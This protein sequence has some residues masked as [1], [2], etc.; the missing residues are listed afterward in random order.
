M[1]VGRMG[2]F[3]ISARAVA[4]GTRFAGVFRITRPQQD[5]TVTLPFQEQDELEETFDTREEAIEPPTRTPRRWSKVAIN[6]R[7]AEG[8][9]AAQ[10]R[11]TFPLLARQHGVERRLEFGDREVVR[12]MGDRSSPL[13]SMATILYQ[14]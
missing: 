12:M 2:E 6:S 7:A 4:Q 5:W 9:Q 11:I 1:K 8:R 3:I 14:V 10:S 13:C